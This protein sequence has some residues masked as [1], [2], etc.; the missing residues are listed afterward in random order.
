MLG[1]EHVDCVDL[2]LGD[3]MKI[4]ICL[5]FGL[6]VY[7][8]GG[9]MNEGIIKDTGYVTVINGRICYY[10]DPL[11]RI[12]TVGR[13]YD[14]RYMQPLPQPMCDRLIERYVKNQ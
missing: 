1:C 11:N 12:C 9:N 4:L 8:C 10:I 13:P 14:M 2:R 6:T 3:L 5:I 7:C